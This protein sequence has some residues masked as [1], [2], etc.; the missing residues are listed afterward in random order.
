MGFGGKKPSAKPAV[1]KPAV[2]PKPPKGKSL[3]QHLAVQLSSSGAEESDSIIVTTASA[4]GVHIRLPGVISTHCPTLDVA[5]GRGG[6]PM[7][8]LT[9][10]TGPESAGKTTLAGHIIV[11]AQAMG[12]IVLYVDAEH[13]L[14]LEYLKALGVN[15]D[16]MLLAQPRH[17]E[18]SFKLF[19]QAVRLITEQHPEKPVLAILDSINANRSKDEY[20]GSYEDQHVG[21]QSR[22]MSRSLP[23]L[24]QV[25]SRK[26]VALLFISQ[27]RD[28]IGSTMS[29]KNKVAGGNA[30]KFYASVIIELIRNGFL[31]VS[32]KPVGS[33]MIAKVIKN[34]VSVPFKEAHFNM[35]WGTGIDYNHNLLERGIQLGLLN[36]GASGWYEFPDPETGEIMKWQGMKAWAKMVEKHPNYLTWIQEQV[37]ASAPL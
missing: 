10:I 14:D 1:A 19:D 16:D 13:K 25:M 5:L 29:Y 26:K 15:V 37:K 17:M 8:R 9:I 12:A 34:Q 32:E 22:V 24:L 11:E 35:N 4:D 23:K 36:R 6:V 18:A 27:I 30:P 31:M 21:A 33:K 20:E 7:G 2:D 3:A 28:A